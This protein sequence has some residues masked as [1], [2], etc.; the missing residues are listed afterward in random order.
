M[1]MDKTDENLMQGY[2][3]IEESIGNPVTDLV[4]GHPGIY[5]NLLELQHA[6]CVILHYNIISQGLMLAWAVS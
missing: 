5:S 4:L 2:M 6:K 1:T 3:N